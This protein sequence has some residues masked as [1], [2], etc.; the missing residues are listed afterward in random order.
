MVITKKIEN[1]YSYNITYVNEPANWML[2]SRLDTP[3]DYIRSNDQTRRQEYWTRWPLLSTLSLSS[4]IQ[5]STHMS[6]SYW[7]IFA[8]SLCGLNLVP[9]C[10]WYWV[11]LCTFDMS[12]CGVF[13]ILSPHLPYVVLYCTSIASFSWL[14][15]E[16]FLLLSNVTMSRSSWSFVL[17]G[18]LLLRHGTLWSGHRRTSHLL[19]LESVFLG[20]ASQTVYNPSRLSLTT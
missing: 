16:S 2:P 6:R 5:Q 3:P 8:S 18:V 11:W 17:D 7:S 19:S 9:L 20:Y 14:W 10:T 4:S 13:L 15:W 12:S 1:N